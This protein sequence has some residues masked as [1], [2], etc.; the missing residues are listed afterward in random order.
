MTPEQLK[1]LTPEQLAAWD[2]CEAATKGPWLTVAGWVGA[3]YRQFL[4]IAGI[5]DGIRN[6]HQ[7]RDDDIQFIAH[8]RTDLPAAL[9]T[10]AEQAE[11]L[12]EMES[13][14]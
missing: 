9:R 3:A 2:R 8:A 6:L 13:K 4:S 12:A 5:A 11:K 10:I 14:G 1:Y 7:L